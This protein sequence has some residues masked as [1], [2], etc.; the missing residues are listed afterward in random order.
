MGS[1]IG[2]QIDIP[3]RAGIV[4]LIGRPSPADFN[5]RTTPSPLFLSSIVYSRFVLASPIFAYINICIGIENGILFFF[6]LHS[7]TTIVKHRP[8]EVLDRCFHKDVWTKGGEAS[9]TRR[10]S[11]FFSPRVRRRR[12]ATGGDRIVSRVSRNR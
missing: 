2:R 5:D 10:G 9:D 12:A 6:S 8:T 11:R 4:T 7:S 3:P 1:V